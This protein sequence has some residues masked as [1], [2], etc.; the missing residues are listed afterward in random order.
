MLISFV[1][2]QFNPTVL[3]YS[4][5]QRPVIPIEDSNFFVKSP[6]LSKSEGSNEY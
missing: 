4:L 1:K 5:T 3:I 6:V 2:F